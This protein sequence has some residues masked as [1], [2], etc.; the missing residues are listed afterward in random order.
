VAFGMQLGF[1][2]T[3]VNDFQINY[4]PTIGIHRL[5]LANTLNETS[6]ALLLPA[7]K[8]IND[9]FSVKLDGLLNL[10]R[11]ATKNIIPNDT[12]Y[13]NNIFSVT[14]SVLY[15]DKQLKLNGGITYLGNNGKMSFMPNIEAEVALSNKRFIFQGGWIGKINKNTFANLSN[16]NPYLIALDSQKNTLET[17]AYFGIKSSVTKH[18]LFS[19]KAALI[20]Y[21][22]YQ[23]FLN[24]TAGANKENRF[25]TSNENKLSNFRL[26][27]DL[28]YIIRDKFNFNGGVTINAYTGLNQNAHAWHLLPMEL[29]ASL[30]WK[31]LTKLTV[32]SDFYLFAGGK[33]LTKANISNRMSGGADWSVGAEYKFTKHIGA[34]INLN[35]IFGKNYERW[36]NYP[37]YGFNILGGVSIR[38]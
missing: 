19:A 28:S 11:Y 23:L 12:A 16:I 21:K 1:K 36:H 31:P 6:F 10:T 17:E 32:K 9:L 22:D 7:E 8:K 18:L 15:H 35:N 34:F 38:F 37:V 24:D 30:S 13:N 25:V 3:A 27:G 4:N 33:Y 14:P 5:S 20:V 29:N 26:H 2:N